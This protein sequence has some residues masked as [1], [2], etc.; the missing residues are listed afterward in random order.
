MRRRERRMKESKTVTLGP[1]GF[2][3]FV[4]FTLPLSSMCCRAEREL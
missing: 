2:L 1:C 3:L 4:C